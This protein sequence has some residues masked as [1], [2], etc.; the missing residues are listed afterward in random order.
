MDHQVLS[1]HHAELDQHVGALL[2]KADGGD[3][4]ELATAWGDFERELLRHFEL[5][6]RELFPRFFLEKPEDATAL[7]REHE[8]LRRD[9]LALGIRADLHCLRAEAVR[10]FIS[11]LRAHAAYEEQALYPW[12]KTNVEGDTWKTIARGL[13][14]ASDT[15]AHRL[16]DELSRLG[17][18]SL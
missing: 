18:Q 9:L 11:D 15:V 8:T 16:A 5:E 6:E 4:H 13:R 17:A 10:A 14:E 7:K 1:R 12:A 3:S 2:T